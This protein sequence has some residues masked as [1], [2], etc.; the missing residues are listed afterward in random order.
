MLSWETQSY[1]EVKRFHLS[2]NTANKESSIYFAIGMM[3]IL[4]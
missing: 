2:E 3:W 1:D 4:F